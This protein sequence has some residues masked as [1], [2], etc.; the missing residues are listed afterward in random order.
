MVLTFTYVIGGTIGRKQPRAIIVRTIIRSAYSKHYFKFNPR[1]LATGPPAR[2]PGISHRLCF[3]GRIDLAAMFG[4]RKFRNPPSRC[5][6]SM[7]ACTTRKLTKGR[8]LVMLY[9]RAPRVEGGGP[10]VWRHT[11]ISKIRLRDML[12][13]K[14]VA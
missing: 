2:R 9:E 10:C 3:V 13:P 14:K 5:R 11:T 12:F 1:F 7:A 6:P 4:Y 8:K